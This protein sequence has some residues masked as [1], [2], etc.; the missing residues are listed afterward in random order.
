MDNK[1]LIIAF[2]NEQIVSKREIT[3]Y[4]YYEE[5][6]PEI[7]DD[8]YIKQ[9][10]IDIVELHIYS[11]G[12]YIKTRNHYNKDGLPYKFEIWENGEYK[13]EEL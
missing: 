4:Q 9:C 8:A 10:N 1:V 11:N 2:S 5:L 6:N 12:N 7:D 13:V 3:L